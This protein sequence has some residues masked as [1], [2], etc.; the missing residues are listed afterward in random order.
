LSCYQRAAENG[1]QIEFQNQE[2]TMTTIETEAAAGIQRK[3]PPRRSR[4]AALAK[5]LLRDRAERGVSGQ[6]RGPKAN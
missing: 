6:N 1:R 5:D 4:A 2:M 3:R